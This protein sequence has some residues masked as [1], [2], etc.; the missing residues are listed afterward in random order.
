MRSG[1]FSA[2]Y[3]PLSVYDG[4]GDV[5]RALGVVEDPLAGYLRARGTYTALAG[6][7]VPLP[8][9][10]GAGGDLHPHPVPG[11]ERDPGLPQIYRVFVD[12]SRLDGARLR[13][14]HDAGCGIALPRTRP[15]YAIRHD[16]CP[17]LGV[18]V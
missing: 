16:D 6:I 17:P 1:I 10:E 2:I 8:A 7:R 15:H 11:P 18:H 4:Q 14:P 3:A 13:R 5:A 9:R 12:P